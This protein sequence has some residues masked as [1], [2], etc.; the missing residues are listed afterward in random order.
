MPVL[1][2]HSDVTQQ[3]QQHKVVIE[4]WDW[5]RVTANDFVGGFSIPVGEILDAGKGGNWME[6]WY[7]LLDEK[8][9]REHYERVIA[10]EEAQLV[11]P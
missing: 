8:R 3:E 10:D 11:C 9:T 6:H 7:K 4:T 2:P 5:D 1:F